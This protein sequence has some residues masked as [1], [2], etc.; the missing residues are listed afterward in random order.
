MHS[1]N[2]GQSVVVISVQYSPTLNNEDDHT[3]R[4]APARA[5][6]DLAVIAHAR[7]TNI[8]QSS[9]NENDKRV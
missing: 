8:R 4:A 1:D 6:I 5:A 2:D 7:E 9:Y 3:C